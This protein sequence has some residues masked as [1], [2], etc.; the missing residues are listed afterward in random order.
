MRGSRDLPF[1][2]T[3]ETQNFR[4][5][6]GRELIFSAHGHQG[7]D[8]CGVDLETGRVTNFS[9]TPDQYDEPGGSRPTAD[10]SSS[11]ATARG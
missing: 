6:D 7:T 2:C 8:A 4:P 1:R 5:P 3:L 9:D 10:G 11:G